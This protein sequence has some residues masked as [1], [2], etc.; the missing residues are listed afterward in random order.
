MRKPATVERWIRCVSLAVLLCPSLVMLPSW[1]RA[2]EA[3]SVLVPQSYGE[4]SANFFAS[5]REL[6]RQEF[7]KDVQFSI[8]NVTDAT[9]RDR[10]VQYDWTL[11]VVTLEALGKIVPPGENPA[12]VFDMPLAYATMANL[13]ACNEEI[14]ESQS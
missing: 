3:V 11:A 7:D 14:W 12:R 9:F 13:S 1:G 6:I 2:T 4:T 10:F 5:T 8:Q